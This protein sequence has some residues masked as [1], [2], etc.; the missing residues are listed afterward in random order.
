[1][2]FVLG[3]CLREVLE[4]E[5]IVHCRIRGVCLCVCGP[6]PAPI[7]LCSDETRAVRWYG[8]YALLIESTGLETTHETT[9]AKRNEH[10][11]RT[12]T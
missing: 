1:M 8:S 9:H 11:P 2:I 12:Y 5:P 4:A 10:A 3:S 7:S 6:L